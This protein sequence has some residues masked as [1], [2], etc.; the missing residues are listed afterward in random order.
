MV[1][2]LCWK[3]L[4]LGLESGISF[5]CFVK[6]KVTNFVSKIEVLGL[7][8]GILFPLLVRERG[9]ELF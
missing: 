1:T 5:A 4:V 8:S 3:I 7:E 6:G 2:N 9:D